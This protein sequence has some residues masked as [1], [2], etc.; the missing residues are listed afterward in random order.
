LFLRRGSEN[1][2]K[3]MIVMLQS[4]LVRMQIAPEGNVKNH[5]SIYKYR[6][7]EKNTIL[8]VIPNQRS[9]NRQFPSVFPGPGK[10]V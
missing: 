7:S 5:P 1:E 8:W 2:L 4:A 9:K 3:K 10:T 6:Q